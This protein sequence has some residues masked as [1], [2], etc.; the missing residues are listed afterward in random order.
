MLREIHP[1]AYS[2]PLNLLLS[3]YAP[4]RMAL[5]NLP[6]NPS[7]WTLDDAKGVP[8]LSYPNGKIDQKGAEATQAY[9]NGDH[10]QKGVAWIGAGFDAAGNW[11]PSSYARFERTLTP[12]P[13]MFACLERRVNGACGIEPD[14]SIS[15]TKPAGEPDKDGNRQPS[16]QQQVAMGEWR[17]DV[18]TKWWTDAGVAGGKDLRHP[19]GARGMVALA[20]ASESGG[21]CLR[22]FVNP[23]SRMI[24]V[25]VG[26]GPNAT[27]E[28]Q[29][30]RQ[31]D[32]AASL[33][34]IKLS[35]PPPDRCCIYVDPDTHERTGVFLY[36]DFNDNDCA[37]VWFA[38]EVGG[39]RLTV[40]RTLTASGFSEKEYPWGGHFPIVDANVGCILTDA[41]RRL[42][43]YLDLGG[44]STARLV[45]SH[46]YGGRTEIGAEP[47]GYWSASKPTMA[48]PGQEPE[49]RI[50]E[51]SKAVEYFW[52]LSADM[53][54]DS[55]RHIV[56]K[57]YLSSENEKGAK[58][59][60]ITSPSIHEHTPS[61][62]E[63]LIRAVE[64]GIV[65]M[66]SACHQG[67]IRTGLT[68]SMAEASGEAYEQAR[69]D[70][71]ADIKAIGEAVDAAVAALL[72][73]VTIM[74]DYFCEVPEPASFAEQWHVAVQ[75][76]PSAGPPSTEWQRTTL[77]M[78]NGE[79]LDAD[80][81]TARLGVQDVAATRTM[82]ARSRSLDRVTK[83]VTLASMAYGSG[84]NVK[85]ALMETGM[86]E[87]DADEWIQSDGLPNASQ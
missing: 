69:A 12:V 26:E 16:K 2:T 44:T 63:A 56:P 45:Q 57:Y 72:I 73:T 80:E 42:Q 84:L 67:H 78:V 64:A 74:A 58:T 77:E 9:I 75:S 22:A 25:T 82:I 33:R 60:S 48:N 38:R 62:P 55:I 68:G 61:D 43:A 29:V 36:K 66:R 65:W 39:R 53:N 20:S 54:P 37:E 11:I 24:E 86:S 6:Q 18:G 17:R 51:A 85:K 10:L 40:H 52:P 14:P 49:A 27:T 76:H 59:W 46:G 87:T 15:P 1:R 3:L 79:L 35:T 83:L 70:F 5:R 8:A 23:A 4:H 13:E 30:P 7:D 28:K 81:G 41:V 50:N 21:A 31:T 19:S 34:H 71:L 32:R 47:D